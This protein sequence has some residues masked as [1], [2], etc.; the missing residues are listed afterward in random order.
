MVGTSLDSNYNRETN[1]GA[2]FILLLSSSLRNVP[3]DRSAL[4]LCMRAHLLIFFQSYILSYKNV[5]G[6]TFQL[7]NIFFG[8]DLHEKS[9]VNKV[10]IKLYEIN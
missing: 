1:N 5:L 6:L 10:M 2:F 4:Y 8:H 7:V 3:F 9:G